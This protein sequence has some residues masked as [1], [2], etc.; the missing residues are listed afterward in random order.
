[1]LSLLHTFQPLVRRRYPEL[2]EQVRAG[3]PP[4]TTTAHSAA[5]LD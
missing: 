3:L 1:V 5:R 2:L 4:D